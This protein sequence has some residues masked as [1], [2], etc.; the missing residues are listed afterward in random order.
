MFWIALALAVIVIYSYMNS[1]TGEQA[2][3]TYSE[4]IAQVESG[5]VAEVTFKD[6][7]IQGTLRESKAFESVQRG[8]TVAKFKTRIPFPDYNYELVSQLQEQNV[9]IVAE[10]DSA[11]LGYLLAAAPWVVP[12]PIILPRWVN[13]M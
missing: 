4:F 9:K 8:Q 13:G 2:E 12:S 6:R 11:L 5:N 1:F 3:I 7:E 10:T